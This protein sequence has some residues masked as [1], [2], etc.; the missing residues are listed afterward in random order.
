M[1]EREAL[2]LTR[3][4]LDRCRKQFR[5]KVLD[6]YGVEINRRMRSYRGI[7]GQ[8]DTKKK[9]IKISAQHVERDPDAE[10]LDTI[11]H[12]IAHA[13]THWDEERKGI[14]H[15]TQYKCYHNDLFYKW[16]VKVGCKPQRCADGPNRPKYADEKPKYVLG[17]QCI[18]K[19]Y[20]RLPPEIRTDETGRV[21]YYS[22]TRHEYWDSKEAYFEY[23]QEVWIKNNRAPAAHLKPIRVEWE[24]GRHYLGCRFNRYRHEPHEKPCGQPVYLYPYDDHDMWRFRNPIRNFKIDDVPPQDSCSASTH[25]PGGNGVV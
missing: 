9:R 3:R 23:F 6:E 14:K 25:Y 21:F 1:T 20:K 11:R 16:C 15:V 19:R 8:C 24:L 17:C 12:E 10:V 2:I 18:R 7:Y 22:W 4:E 5:C 13:I